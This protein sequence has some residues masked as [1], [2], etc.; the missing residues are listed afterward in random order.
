MNLDQRTALLVGGG[1]TPGATMGNG[2]ATALAFAKDGAKTKAS[3][4]RLVPVGDTLVSEVRRK[5][6]LAP[7]APKPDKKQK[8][9]SL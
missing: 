6:L 9:G 5:E 2:R 7:A 3:S 8:T 4:S 1:Q